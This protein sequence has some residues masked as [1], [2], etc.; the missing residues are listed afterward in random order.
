[1]VINKKRKFVTNKITATILLS[2]ISA[3]AYSVEFNTDMLD[4]EDKNNIDFSKFSNA[5]YIMPGIYELYVNVNKQ[6]ISPKSYLVEF[7]ESEGSNNTK[8][9]LTK[10]IVEKIALK[11]K[12]IDDLKWW[13]NGK[14]AQLDVLSGYEVKPDIQSGKLHI[15]IPQAWLEYS[16]ATWL[17]PSRWDEGIPGFMFDYNIN[18]NSNKPHHGGSYQSVYYFGTAGANYGPWRLRA[19]YQGYIQHD[20][21][22]TQGT[23]DRFVWNRLY[24][25]RAI[26]SLE[27]KL[28]IG[29]NYI[30]S[31]IFSSW[32]YTGVSLESDDRMLPP[33]LR[34]YAP[35][36]SGV[37][38]TNARVVISQ[39]GRILYDATVPAG[40]FTIQDLESSVRGRLDVAVIEQNGD[41]KTFYVDTAYVPY[42]TRPGHIRYKLVSGR[43][44]TWERHTE[45]PIF[46][47][48]EMAW[49]INNYWT[50]YGGGIFTN[51]YNSF[52]LGIGR[53]LNRF[54]TI[55][56]DITQSLAELQDEG[57][58]HGK[59]LRVSYS[60]RFDDIN[61]DITFAGYRFT[62]RNYMTMQQFL[63]AR[64]RD[65]ISGRE[66]ELYTVT[67]NKNFVEH[68][69]SLS[70]QYSR[71]TYWDRAL[72]NYYTISYNKYFDIFN[73]KNLSLGVTASKSKLNEKDND[74][75]FV[76]LTVP[77]GTGRASY[78]GS[79]SNDQYTHIIGYSDSIHD[80]L[81]SYSI[82]TG[83]SHGGS[84]S[85][86]KQASAYYTYNTPLTNFSANISAVENN[87]TSFGVNL[88]G[89]TTITKHGAAFHAGGINGSTRLLV[90]T[91]GISNVPV[92]SGRVLTNS[93]GLGVVTEVNSYYRNLT[94]IDV[95]KLPKDMEAKRSVVETILTEGAIGY[96]KFEVLKGERLFAVIRLPDGS[97]PPFGATVVNKKGRELGMLSESGLV[98]LSGI[99]SGETLNVIW[100]GKVQ[101]DVSIP[102][103]IKPEQQ[104]LLPCI[105]E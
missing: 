100:N 41:K 71:Q 33:K 37:A 39:Q 62:E 84:E 46:V 69:S 23:T 13:D 48:G 16:D 35:E 7:K 55:S 76:R 94:A 18:A 83:F 10:D 72:S 11:Q 70:V 79:M 66:K 21:R 60:K 12:V 56:T 31:D 22:L 49:G 30:N 89:G 80:G 87:Y 53:D 67:V 3:K 36:I 86:Q 17:P 32:N 103:K 44:R 15:N 92:D 82:N 40:P 59:S 88:S 27:S 68:Q 104:L 58:Q 34:G 28:T 1:M 93:Q 91:D 14:C 57:Y 6:E 63:D 47:G 95:N 42:L 25:Y 99:N 90:D 85:N 96:R 2:L 4:A 98:W 78:G 54:G 97:Y 102:E 38:D 61:T 51:K 29:E 77:F 8:I 9:C 24:L 52:A 50:L 64:Y 105:S 26:P 19:D 20:N 45:G 73:F 43:S 101:C 65:N 5:G 74:S 75:V 81:G